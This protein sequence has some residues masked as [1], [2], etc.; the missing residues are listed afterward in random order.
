M[1]F[2]HC[3]F[4]AAQRALDMDSLPDDLLPLVI[5]SEVAARTGLDSEPRWATAWH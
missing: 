2:D 5:V 3:V 1:N 4:E